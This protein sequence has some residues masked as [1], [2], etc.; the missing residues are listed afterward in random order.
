MKLSRC[1]LR[2][3]GTPTGASWRSVRTWQGHRTEPPFTTTIRCT[4]VDP[5]QFVATVF[6]FGKQIFDTAPCGD[7]D[8]AD[9][10]AR[11]ELATRMQRLLA[12]AGE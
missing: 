5:D 11:E 10:A 4:D 12:G 3:T 6:V 7:V 9:R 8:A 1:N 2:V